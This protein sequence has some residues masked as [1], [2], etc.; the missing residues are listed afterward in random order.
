MNKRFTFYLVKW[1]NKK[2]TLIVSAADSVQ[3][4]RMVADEYPDWAVS[5]FWPCWPF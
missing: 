3:A 5:M 2:K 4:R 1:E